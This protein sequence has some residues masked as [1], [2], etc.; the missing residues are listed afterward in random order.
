[1]N[2]KVVRQIM[3][4]NE[5]CHQELK[6]YFDDKGVLVINIM[7]SPGCGKTTFISKVIEKFKDKYNFGVV[8]AD[9]EGCIDAEKISSMGVPVVQLN[10][11][12]ACHIEAMSIKEIISDFD[13]EKIDILFIENIGNLVCPAEFDLGED[14]KLALLSVPEGD[15][16]VIKYPI[17]FQRTDV[18]V[19]TKWD[20]K[21]YFKFNYERIREDLSIINNDAELF[22]VNSLNGDGI[23]NVARMIEEKVKRK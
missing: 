2:I 17:M 20:M 1:M 16:K 14:L 5:D 19:L 22:T 4:W 21:E 11:E 10:T 15:D 6:N 12:G 8:E 18:V 3:E 13:L 9:L 7:G 23:D